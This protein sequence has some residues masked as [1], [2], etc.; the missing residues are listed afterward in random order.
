M[1]ASQKDQAAVAR[2]QAVEATAVEE[3]LVEVERVRAAVVRA[4]A[5]ATAQ[6]VAETGREGR[7]A[8]EEVMATAGVS[9]A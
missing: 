4:A 2:E 3:P 7:E 1:E 5:G 9:R 6:A 8:A